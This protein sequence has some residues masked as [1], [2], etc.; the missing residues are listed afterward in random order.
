MAN[1]LTIRKKIKSVK[2]TRKIT[3]A[4]QL[5]A[6]SKMRQFQKKAVNSRLYAADLLKILHNNLSDT[7]S[8]ALM[9]K[10]DEG[11]ILFI[12]YSSDKGLCGPL[13]NRMIKALLASSLWDQT[14][15]DERL[16]IT[17][18]KKSHD[19][20]HYNKIKVEKS[21]KS[22]NEDMKPSDALEMVDHVMKFWKDKVV[23]EIVMIAPYYKSPIVFY[24][25][26]KTYLP[27]SDEMI[28]K[29][30]S[31]E[32]IV[33]GKEIKKDI[34]HHEEFMIFEPNKEKFKESLIEQIV[35]T[36]F[37][38]AFY[39][40]KAS[41]YSSRM[42]AMQSAT[43]AADDMTSNLTLSLNK[44]RQTIITQEIAEIVAGSSAL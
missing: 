32:E 10:R 23:K 37:V 1:L 9:E 35:Q 29:H 43:D 15:K 5:V 42:I 31:V 22:L 6:A 41:E 12:L 25:I 24:P 33:E 28:S 11:K 36:L 16:L 20:A 18:G 40:L 19:F 38:Q 8:E 17:I 21:F 27:F 13:N 7:K 3:K 4:M 39:E 30:L 26:V 44:A 14:D 2:N 34:F